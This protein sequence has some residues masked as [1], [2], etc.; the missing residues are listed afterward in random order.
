MMIKFSPLSVLAIGFSASFTACSPILLQRRASVT[1]TTK[2]SGYLYSTV[3]E[4]VTDTSVSSQRGHRIGINNDN[5]FIH[6]DVGDKFLFDECESDGWNSSPRQFG[7]LKYVPQGEF[8]AVTAD[9]TTQGSGYPLSMQNAS[10]VA[11]DMLDRQWFYAYWKNDKQGGPYVTVHVKGNPNDDD[12]EFDLP[13]SAY[14]NGINTATKKD[15]G[16]VYTLFDVEILS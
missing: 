5:Y 9:T 1:C 13:Y 4:N 2:Y 7:Q 16:H 11:D 14:Y 6:D 3:I 8:R 15:T 12:D 10:S